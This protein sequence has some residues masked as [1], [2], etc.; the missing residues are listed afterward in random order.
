MGDDGKPPEDCL[1]NSRGTPTVP[2]T[3]G[4]PTR[5]EKGWPKASQSFSTSAYTL[6]K[7]SKI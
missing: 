2:D 5:S 4:M 1:D 6:V 7:I 3:V